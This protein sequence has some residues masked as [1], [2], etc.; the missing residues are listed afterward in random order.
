M[1]ILYQSYI[2]YKIQNIEINVL[3]SKKQR[4]VIYQAAALLRD[5]TQT[6]ET[7]L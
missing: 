5:K 4:I 1:L 7:S 6:N 3:K 2:V